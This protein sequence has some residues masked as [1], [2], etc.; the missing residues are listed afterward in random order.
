VEWD[1]A[2]VPLLDELHPR[3]DVDHLTGD[4]VTEDESLRRRRATAD[5]VL[6]RATDVGGDA[7]ENRRVGELATHVGGV[8]A[9][10]VLELE[11]WEVD[12]VDLHL[13]RAH[14]GNAS[15]IRHLTPLSSAELGGPSKL[16]AQPS[17]FSYPDGSLYLPDRSVGGE[18]LRRRGGRACP[19]R[20]PPRPVD[21]RP[22]CA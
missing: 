21:A 11:P 19:R 10:P 3:T 20:K 12:V 2:Q 18:P 1:R 4:L 6:V 8:D 15:V 16:S 5:H 13:P 14:V 9:R 17:R 7:L 22:A